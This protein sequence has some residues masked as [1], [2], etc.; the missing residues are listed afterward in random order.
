MTLLIVAGR[1]APNRAVVFGGE[2]HHLDA[3][4]RADVAALAPH[5]TSPPGRSV[6]VGPEASVRQ[7]AAVLGLTG[8]VDPALASLDLGSWRG[9]TPEQI[10]GA[11]LAR[12]FTDP[13][14]VPH[15]GES[16]AGF[17]ARIRAT[18][19]GDGVLVVAK[20]VAQALLCAAA[21]QFFAT[22]LRPASLH[23]L[24]VSLP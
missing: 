22:E 19:T 6:R 4:G 14:V 20:P 12:W 13:A 10:P 24:T 11:D 15:G 3:R 17:V 21:D 23:R 16:V 2:H 18:V 9:L 8:A 1:T 5:L 7:S